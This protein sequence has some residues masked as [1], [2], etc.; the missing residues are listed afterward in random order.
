MHESLPSGVSFLQRLDGAGHTREAAWRMLYERYWDFILSAAF[1]RGL[2]R[3]RAEGVLQET[4]T[5]LLTKLPEVRKTYPAKGKF[6]SYVYGL[7][8]HVTLEEVRRAGLEK[9]RQLSL[10]APL[11]DGE[12][13]DQSKLIEHWEAGDVREEIKQ[14]EESAFAEGLLRRALA[15]VKVKVEPATWR[16]FEDYVV[17]GMPAPQVAQLHGRQVNAVYQIKK[18]LESQ[19]TREV[20]RL[21]S[22]LDE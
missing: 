4:L 15:E 22:E 5:R 19:I 9:R 18:R 7:A 11:R 1:R 3:E 2:D 12:G 8:R 14:A 10:D 20:E 13:G 16:V 17:E 21:R 6:R